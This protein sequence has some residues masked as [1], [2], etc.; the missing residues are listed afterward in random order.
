MALIQVVKRV[1][2]ALVVAAV[3]LTILELYGLAVLGVIFTGLMLIYALKAMYDL[4]LSKLES[5]NAL[6]KLKEL[7]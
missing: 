5:R 4:E 3:T 2:F 7:E 6:T 1:L